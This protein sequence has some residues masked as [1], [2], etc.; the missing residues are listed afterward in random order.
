MMIRLGRLL[1]LALLVSTLGCALP[2]V[3]DGD[4]VSD[5]PIP[6][7]TPSGS[8]RPAAIPV[9]TTQVPTPTTRAPEVYYGSCAEVRAAG[10]APIR[11][12]QPGYRSGL[13]RDGDGVACD[14]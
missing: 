12:G 11:R 1:V 5:P 4:D 2:L 9:P 10:K 8:V 6:S 14:T 13:D 7:P 3:S